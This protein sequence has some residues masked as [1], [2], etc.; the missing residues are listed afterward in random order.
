MKRFENSPERRRDAKRRLYAV[1]AIKAVFV[2]RR[3]AKRRLYTRN[4]SKEQPRTR[5][6]WRLC[7]WL[8]RR[9][10]GR[11]RALVESGVPEGGRAAQLLAEVGREQVEVVVALR[12]QLVY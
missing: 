3:D 8:G 1:L 9:N 2:Q 5:G 6:Y 12:V 7:R 4:R 10:L 11:S